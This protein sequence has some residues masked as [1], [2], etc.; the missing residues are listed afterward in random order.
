MG[1][2]VRAR[3]AKGALHYLADRRPSRHRRVGA[4][5]RHGLDR[6]HFPGK[7]F[8][9]KSNIGGDDEYFALV[10]GTSSEAK[11]QELLAKLDER[12]QVIVLG[13]IDPLKLPADANPN[14]SMLSW[15][16]P[17][18]SDF[19]TAPAPRP[20]CRQSCSVSLTEKDLTRRLNHF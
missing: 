1:E 14:Y 5:V 19:P 4:A 16:A 6:L 12:P 15:R 13:N 20:L 8:Q 17:D 2:T 18:S 10:E 11:T 9:Q 3:E 7:Y